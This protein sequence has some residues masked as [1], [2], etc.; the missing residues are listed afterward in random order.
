MQT[1]LCIVAHYNSLDTFEKVLSAYN[2]SLE[3]TNLNYRAAL[4]S[5][6]IGSN[7]DVV[8]YFLD[9]GFDVNA[10]YETSASECNTL[11]S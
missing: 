8:R 6:A 2:I 11:L 3:P 7:A 9:R 4:V 5:A 1:F 10:L